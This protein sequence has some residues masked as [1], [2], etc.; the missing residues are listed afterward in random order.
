MAQIELVRVD[1]RLI[2]GQVITKWVRQTF[3]NRIVIIDDN[4]AKDEFMRSIYVMA[5]PSNIEVNVYSVES[6]INNWVE[7]EM[8]HGK[9]FIL[10]KDVETAFKTIKG[11]VPIKDLQIGGLGAGP[12]R[13][14][15]FG[16]I[17]L[18]EEDANLLRELDQENNCHVYLHQVPD[19]PKMELKKALE[20][21][22]SLKNKN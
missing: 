8:G 11:G 19:E 17:T 4:L 10:F 3:A 18:N 13:K 20:K 12:G 6:A 15:I 14:A 22:D 21:L 7:N 16:P 5:A 9:L 2:H 1:F